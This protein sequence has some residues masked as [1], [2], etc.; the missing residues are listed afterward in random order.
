ME[1]NLT[2]GNKVDAAPW[3]EQMREN[4]LKGVSIFNYTP[5]GTTTSGNNFWVEDDCD[6]EKYYD[7]EK[8]S[9]TK[10]KKFI[11]KK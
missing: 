6:I 11:G 9:I 5:I 1:I 8:S 3:I 10:L 2:N 4:V 7:I